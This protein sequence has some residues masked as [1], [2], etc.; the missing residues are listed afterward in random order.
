[1]VLDIEKWYPEKNFRFTFE[2]YFLTLQDVN[3]FPGITKGV[4]FSLKRQFSY[5]QEIFFFFL[6]IKQAYKVCTA[7]FFL[8]I[9]LL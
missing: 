6:K 3:F 4:I 2:N 9:N 8:G 5:F 1:M 7:I